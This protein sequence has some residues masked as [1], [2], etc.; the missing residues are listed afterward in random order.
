MRRR[1]AHA[2]ISS[3]MA[4]GARA[5]PCTQWSH[6]CCSAGACRSA[7]NTAFRPLGSGLVPVIAWYG[8]GA[9]HSL[10]ETASGTVLGNSQT[11]FSGVWQVQAIRN[12]ATA[13]VLHH[14]QDKFQLD[15]PCSLLEAGFSRCTIKEKMVGPLVTAIYSALYLDLFQTAVEAAAGE[16]VNGTETSRCAL[17]PL[18]PKELVPAA[19]LVAAAAGASWRGTLAASAHCLHQSDRAADT[20]VFRLR[21]FTTAACALCSSAF[22]AMKIPGSTSHP[23]CS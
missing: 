8:T 13:A 7:L 9:G 23:R 18:M 16:G 17:V 10:Q 20:Y 21:Q 22:T 3:S 11:I 15:R 12:S 5:C 4:A 1:P 6:R 2:A 19:A 14:L